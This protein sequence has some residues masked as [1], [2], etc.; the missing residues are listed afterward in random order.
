[1][2]ATFALAGYILAGL[3]SVHVL[4]TSPFNY[5]TI[6]IHLFVGGAIGGALGAIIEWVRAG[7]W[8]REQRLEEGRRRAEEERKRAE[9]DRQQTL[10]NIERVSDS[11]IA[12]LE[13][14]PNYLAHANASLNKAEVA[15]QDRAFS[16]FWEEIEQVAVSLGR[17]SEAVDVIEASRDAYSRSLQH[18]I[19]AEDLTG[20]LSPFPITDATV[21]TLRVCDRATRR[22][23]DL[24]REAQR[25]FQFATIFEQRRTNQILV[26]GFKSLGD[27][28]HNMSNRI[29]SSISSLDR[30]INEASSTFS[31]YAARHHADAARFQA[32][33]AA[34]S[35]AQAD[36]EKRILA[37]LEKSAR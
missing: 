16:P 37:A 36:R 19:S 26:A 35:S 13:T 9:R 21:S 1:M 11:A 32:Q 15:F 2:L 28:V 30:S 33:F 24:V 8:A 7:R 27:A 31:S 18:L 25:D 10:N 34:A 4:G 3:Y 12:A 20:T 23:S 17:Y 5:G 14:L 29:S 6:I 22:L